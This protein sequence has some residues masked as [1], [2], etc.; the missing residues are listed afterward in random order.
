MRSTLF[1]AFEE[2]ARQN[3][4]QTLGRHRF[5]ESVA[6]AGY[7]FAT[8]R[9]DRGFVGLTLLPQSEWGG[10]IDETPEPAT[11]ARSQGA[12]GADH[13]YSR[14]TSVSNKGEEQRD[15]GSHM[16]AGLGEPAPSAPSTSEVTWF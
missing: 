16:K 3:R 15:S 8:R 2:W 9:G 4:R 1:E 7:R 13:S 11:P 10:P 5:F 6:T 14:F 12:E